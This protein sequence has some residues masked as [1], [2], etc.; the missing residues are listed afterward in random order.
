MTQPGGNCAAS[1]KTGCVTHAHDLAGR[2]TG[3]DYADTATRDITAIT[4]DA[5]A[6]ALR[7]AGR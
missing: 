7:V 1:P 5:V 3:V 2:P 6:A 4:Y